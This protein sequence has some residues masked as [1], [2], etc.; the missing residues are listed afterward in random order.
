[1]GNLIFIVDSPISMTV[2]IKPTI[3]NPQPNNGLPAW[4][5]ISPRSLK[6]IPDSASATGNLKLPTNNNN[7]NSHDDSPTSVPGTRN[8]V[9]PSTVGEALASLA[10]ILA[11]GAQC[12][13]T[14][15]KLADTERRAA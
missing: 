11:N 8:T 14:Y 2:E 13:S 10:Q 5:G 12:A 1:M 9:P 7:E 3:S 15:A 4:V 6:S